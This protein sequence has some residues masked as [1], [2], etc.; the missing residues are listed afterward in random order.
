MLVTTSRENLA[1]TKKL[2][3]MFASD[4]AADQ[5]HGTVFSDLTELIP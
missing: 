4:A 2:C 3:A 1:Q 5:L